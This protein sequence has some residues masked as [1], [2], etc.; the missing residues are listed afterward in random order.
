MVPLAVSLTP[1]PSILVSE[2]CLVEYCSHSSDAAGSRRSSSTSIVLPTV[3]YSTVQYSTVQYSTV[4]YSTVQYS[5][6]RE[7]RAQVLKPRLASHG[8]CICRSICI[9]IGIGIGMY[10]LV[11]STTSTRVC[12]CKGCVHVLYMHACIHT[13]EYCRST[14]YCRYRYVPRLRRESLRFALARIG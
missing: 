3:Q 4:Q 10:W 12:V 14:M 5:T 9:G 6:P 2:E 13:G 7:E 1:P 8:I 11:C